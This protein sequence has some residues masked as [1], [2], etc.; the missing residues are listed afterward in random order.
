MKIKRKHRI[1]SFVLS[2]LMVCSL[3]PTTAFAEEN[4]SG[5]TNEAT[6]VTTSDELKEAIANAN[7]GDTITLGAGKFTTAGNT[8]PEKSLTFVG[9]GKDTVWT[10]GDLTKNVGGE[11]NG[12]YSFDGCDT[13]TFKDMTLKSDGVDYRGF[14]RVNNTV[15]ENC[16]LNGKTAY[17]GYKTAKFVNTT[18][19]APGEDYA[20]WD[21]STQDMSF[22][23]C[24]FNVAGKTV[25]VYVE[26]GNA[27]TETR[28]VAMSGSTINS[29]KT[30][31]AVLNIKNATQ[32]YEVT[33]SGTNTVTGLDANATTG[34]YLYQVE[35]TEVTDTTGKTVTIKEA[36]GDGTYKVVYE[37]KAK[38]SY[39]AKVGED[40]Y[41]TLQAA[42]NAA[43]RGST[44]QLIADT[45]ENVEITK[46]ITLDL[47]GYTLNGGTEANKAALTITNQTVTVKDSSENQTGKIKREDT[48]ENSEDTS[49]YVIDVQG[50]YGLLKFESGN[51]ENNS[52]TAALVRLG[53]ASINAYPTLTIY[54]GIFTQ[55]N[56]TAIKVERGTL[57]VKDG[58]TINCKNGEAVS[59]GNKAYIQ[60]GTINGAVTSLVDADGNKL[61][62]VTISGGTINGDVFAR[63]D[64]TADKT[65]SVIITGGT[66]TGKLATYLGKDETEDASI[67]SIKVTGG[68]FDKDPS[69]YTSEEAEVSGI[70]GGK[71]TVAKTVL[72]MVGDK[73]YYTMEDAFAAQTESK[74][75]IVLQRNYTTTTAFSSGSINRVLNLNG[76]TYTYAPKTVD[77]DTAAFEIN[78]SDVTLTV[79]NGTV[80]SASMIGLIPS[81][82][83]GTITYNNSALVFDGVTMT[84]NGASG[85]ET[86]GSNTNDA[87]T[88][89]D[90]TLDVPNG[91]GIY[92][93][94]SGTLTI[95]NTKITAKTMGVQV[96]AG[97]L[98]ITGDSG[99]T[100]TGDSVPKTENDGAIQDGAAISIID[101]TG[102]KGL[103]KVEI[104]DGTFTSKEG[105]AA[106]KA[107]KWENSTESTFEKTDVIA[108]SGGTFSSEIPVEYCQ[109]SDGTSE[110][111][112]PVEIRNADGTVVYSVDNSVQANFWGG[113]LKMDYYKNTDGTTDY[114]KTDLRFGYEYQIN[115]EMNQ[116]AV[117]ITAWGWKYSVGDESLDYTLEGKNSRANTGLGKNYATVTNLLITGVPVSAYA[118]D[119]YSQ[120]YVT[121]EKDGKTYTAKTGID[122]RSVSEI[123]NKILDDDTAEGI[124]KKYAQGL[125]NELG[126]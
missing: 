78:Y 54:T 62:K 61:S 30:N 125:K 121:Y 64:G 66:I 75:P 113:Q 109:S 96:C 89:K 119:I 38:A 12:D 51:V 102:Y 14:I 36:Q 67:A 124:Q 56:S 123:V 11:G 55:N 63:S 72:A 52:K 118:I 23:G 84:A 27:G 98:S 39:V 31:K 94:S 19:N 77:P 126:K 24:T 40:E 28:K 65:A 92:F 82:M 86:N 112:L 122:H 42:V 71:Y 91:Y 32:A 4:A 85:F 37:V 73:S 16:V 35:T 17:W 20:L 21:Y 5:E 90:C 88:L 114:T 104:K 95:E 99:I 1:L 22:D 59:N 9:S 103:G 26:A 81:A 79:E 25:N 107:Y 10:I 7:N 110:G 48:A 8:S 80:I 49:Y 76:H 106:V 111:Y 108:I 2:F 41:E 120:M 115:P 87:I 50:K 58:T 69:K 105:N 18:F 15:V 97:N 29:T 53:D 13:I 47:N 74:K 3:V 57:Y 93:P 101:R 33:F 43:K 46:Q 70:E 68:T 44:V 45:K 100:V 117:K 116:D 6:V 34:S 60:G 83:K